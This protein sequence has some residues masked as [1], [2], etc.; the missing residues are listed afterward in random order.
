[1]FHRLKLTVAA[2]SMLVVPNTALAQTVS[3]DIN[4]SS[5][6]SGACGLGVPAQTVL[7]LL[8][9]SGSDGRLDSSKR[10]TST[11]AS[12]VI[13]DAW[14][15]APHSLTLDAKPM[16][17]QETR[18]YAQPV[19]MAREIT[20][21]AKLVGWPVTLVRRPKTGDDG[22]SIEMPGPYAPVSPGLVLNVSHLETLTAGKVEDA[23]LMLEPG[24]YKGTV[25]ITLATVN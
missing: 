2:A 8:N 20:Y 16:A 4:L 21:D 22:V 24:T 11:L 15:N 13:S 7:N 14:C 5:T 1:M 19:Y 17:L 3:S 6:V 23:S 25:T 18:S 12:T 9:L 10:S